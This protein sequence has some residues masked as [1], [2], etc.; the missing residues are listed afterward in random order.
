VAVRSKE[1]ACAHTR[2][3][4][5]MNTVLMLIVIL[6]WWKGH[7]YTESLRAHYTWKDQHFRGAWTTRVHGNGYQC[8]EYHSRLLSQRTWGEHPVISPDRQGVKTCGNEF[9]G[10]HISFID[11]KTSSVHRVCVFTGSTRAWRERERERERENNMCVRE[12]ETYFSKMC[13]YV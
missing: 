1:N 3:S 9:G 6:R 12:R 5:V 2:A 10:F 11:V 7:L 8:C 4:L 13:E